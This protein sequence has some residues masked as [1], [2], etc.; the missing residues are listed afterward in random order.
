MSRGWQLY[1][2]AGGK[3]G[4]RW[5]SGS[6]QGGKSRAIRRSVGPG[7]GRLKGKKRALKLEWAGNSIMAIA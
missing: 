6:A 5:V 7:G 3:R 1:E 2:E 4:Y